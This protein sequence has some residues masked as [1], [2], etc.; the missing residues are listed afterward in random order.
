[1]EV[2]QTHI[3]VETLRSLTH[4]QLRGILE[5]FSIDDGVGPTLPTTS[6]MSAQKLKAAYL[7]VIIPRIKVVEI[8]DRSRFREIVGRMFIQA[9]IR[10]HCTSWKIK[11]ITE[12]YRDIKIFINLSRNVI[13][14][15][16]LYPT[17]GASEQMYQKCLVHELN[18]CYKYDRGTICT[19][20]TIDLYYPPKPFAMSQTEALSKNYLYIGRHNRTDIE[21]M[22]WMFELKAVECLTLACTHQLLN[23][24]RQTEYE[25]GIL[26]NFNQ[27]TGLIDWKFVCEK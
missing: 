14:G 17:R 24:I 25:R 5:L 11:K 2:I 19:E 26:I 8:I 15:I 27:K 21:F 22:G 16:G 4:S 10:K 13:A 18:L 6:S 23:Y 20:R 1:M 3:S 12:L 9:R 7:E